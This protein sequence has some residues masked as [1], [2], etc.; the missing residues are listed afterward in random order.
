[1]KHVFSMFLVV[2]FFCSY[3]YAFVVELQHLTRSLYSLE[4]Y[5]LAAPVRDGIADFDFVRDAVP[6]EGIFKKNWRLI[7]DD[8]SARNFSAKYMW[9]YLTGY[10]PALTVKV[11][12][13]QGAL[14][15][16]ITYNYYA[17]DRMGHVSILAVDESFRKKGYGKK[18]L[19]YAFKSLG[20]Q[21]ASSV[22][23]VTGATNV[24]AQSLYEKIGMHKFREDENNIWYRTFN[25]EVHDLN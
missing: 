4:Q 24:A 23:L 5:L 1:M 9:D 12:Y 25:L 3:M 6:L 8:P 18:L 13:E 20:S 14:A 10:K 2:S 22:W 21:G 7:V 15:G 11:L 16:F 19:E 17:L